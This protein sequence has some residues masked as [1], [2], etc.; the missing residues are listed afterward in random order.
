MSL[1][2]RMLRDIG[3]TRA[4][5]VGC[6]SSSLPGDSFDLLIARRDE[7]RTAWRPEFPDHPALSRLVGLSAEAA[8]DDPTPDD[9]VRAERLAA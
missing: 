7:R 1:D 9:V 4:D 6:F 3:L 2:D 5:V 8:A